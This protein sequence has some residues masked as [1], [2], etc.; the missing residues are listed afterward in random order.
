LL[1]ASRSLQTRRAQPCKGSSRR[2]YA[3]YTYFCPTASTSP[4]PSL[5]S[6]RPKPAQAADRS[7]ALPCVHERSTHT[8]GSRR[9]PAYIHRTHFPSVDA[10][11]RL[12]SVVFP[13]L[14]G[15]LLS[16]YHE[17]LPSFPSE[18]ARCRKE[19]QRFPRIPRDASSKAPRPRPDF[20]AA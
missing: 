13:V 15:F 2:T 10:E 4:T 14:R 3:I 8:G 18:A 12:L 9:R 17:P 1:Q 19:P 7:P 16:P 20:R 5:T 11:H 6:L